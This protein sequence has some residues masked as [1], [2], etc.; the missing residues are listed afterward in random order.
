MVY[1][2]LQPKCICTNGYF[3]PRYL[4]YSRVVDTPFTSK[5]H[6]GLLAVMHFSYMVSQLHW[7]CLLS[8]VLGLAEM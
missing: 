1:S 5:S 6:F 3:N 7:P 4:I 8:T 2:S